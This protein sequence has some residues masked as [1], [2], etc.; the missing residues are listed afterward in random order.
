MT[1]RAVS[2]EVPGW[3]EWAFTTTAHPAASAEAVSP[4]ATEKANGKFEAE[5]TATVPSGRSTRR[6]SGRGGTVSGS[7][8]SMVAST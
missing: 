1:T 8:E 6:R 7:G 5:N 3:A 4:P 2:R